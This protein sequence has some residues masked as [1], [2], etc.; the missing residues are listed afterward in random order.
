M[1]VSNCTKMQ[2][3]LSQNFGLDLPVCQKKKK[4]M[5]LIN[6]SGKHRHHATLPSSITVYFAPKDSNNDLLKYSVDI[7][8][9]G[10][11][12]RINFFL[13]LIQKFFFFSYFHVDSRHAIKQLSCL[14]ISYKYTTISSE[15]S[16]MLLV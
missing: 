2:Q 3:T 6:E 5:Q 13:H 10:W 8:K 4:M 1:S 14:I 9:H 7:C 15:H 12:S 11:K 16:L